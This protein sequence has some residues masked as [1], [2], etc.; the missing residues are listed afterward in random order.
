MTEATSTVTARYR[1][2]MTTTGRSTD[3]ADDG[4]TPATQKWLVTC[5]FGRG[6]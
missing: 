4:E 5:L 6:S 3:D 1:R 2:P